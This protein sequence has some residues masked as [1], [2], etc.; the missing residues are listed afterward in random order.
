MQSTVNFTV[1]EAAASEI[2]RIAD[3]Q[4]I[5]NPILR[6]RVVPGGC[7][8]FQYAMGFDESIEENDRVVELENGVKIAIDEFSARIGLIVLDYVQDFIGGGFTIKNPNAANSCG[9]GNSFS[10]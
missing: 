5:E 1:T 2:K 8:G 10:C 4:G 7:S 6:V 9:C 3:E